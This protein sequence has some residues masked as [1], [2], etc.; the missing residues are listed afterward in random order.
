MNKVIL[1]G[2]I[3]KDL[4]LR[5]TAGGTAVANTSLATSKKIKGEQVT[6]WHN[7]VFW[8]KTA[9]LAAKYFKKGD[10][11]SVEGEIEYRSYDTKDGE[12]KYITEIRVSQL[13]FVP[14]GA[15]YAQS[16]ERGA[17]SNPAPKHNGLPTDSVPFNPDD[18]IPF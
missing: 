4:E 5:Y 16:N 13:H 17:Q 12:K 2:R 11:L 14:G 10:P 8:D 15:A 1:L 7:L 3:G 9:E 6:Q 18:D